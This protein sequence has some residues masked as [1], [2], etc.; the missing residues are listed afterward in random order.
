MSAFQYD[1]HTAWLVVACDFPLL[2]HDAIQQLVSERDTSS[3]ATS[4]L[5]YTP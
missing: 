1:P 4:F 3:I 5:I 2:D